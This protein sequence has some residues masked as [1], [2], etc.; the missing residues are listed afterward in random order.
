[1]V[2][3]LFAIC[4]YQFS[5]RIADISDARPETSA[6]CDP[7]RVTPGDPAE[8][9]P[10]NPAEVAPGSSAGGPS[11]DSAAPGSPAGGPS[12]NSSAAAPGN[13]AGV[14]SRSPVGVGVGA[15]VSGLPAIQSSKARRGAPQRRSW[16]SA[17]RSARAWARGRRA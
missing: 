16:R 7:A 11:G 2:F 6:P 3:G 12:G 14:P 15:G 9:A 17:R 8:T 5:P 1:M 4:G 13:P 10:G